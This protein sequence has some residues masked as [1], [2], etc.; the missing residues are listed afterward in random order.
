[1]Y[2]IILTNKWT[3]RRMAYP[4]IYDNPPDLER[5]TS[6]YSDSNWSKYVIYEEI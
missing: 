6:M 3:G 1:M 2:I 5:E 4:K